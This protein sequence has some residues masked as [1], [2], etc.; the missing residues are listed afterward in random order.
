MEMVLFAGKIFGVETVVLSVPSFT[1]NVPNPS[2]FEYLRA[3]QQRVMQFVPVDFPAYQRQQQQQ[4]QQNG[5]NTTTVKH[6]MGLRLDRLIDE[7]IEWNARIISLNVN[8]ST[9]HAENDW[10]MLPQQ[11]PKSPWVCVQCVITRLPLVAL[12]DKIKTF[13]Q[14]KYTFFSIFTYIGQRKYTY[15]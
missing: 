9:A 12:L 3:M 13:G 8:T 1:N 5:K 2:E 4:Q 10:R 14:R 6:V 11:A 15:M 7:V